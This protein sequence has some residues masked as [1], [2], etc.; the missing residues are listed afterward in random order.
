MLQKH[1]TRTLLAPLLSLLVIAAC[2]P[3]G[4]TVKVIENSAELNDVVVRLVGAS[5]TK[6]KEPS[7]FIEL[8]TKVEIENASKEPVTQVSY[9]IKLIG[10]D[11]EELRSY[12]ERYTAIDGAIAPGE[13]RIDDQTGC[14]WRDD[15]TLAGISI[16][17]VNVKTEAQMPLVHLPQTGEYLY[18]ALGN[19]RIANIKNEAPSKMTVGI[20]QGGFLREAR[21]E[22]PGDVARAVELFCDIRVGAQ[23]NEWVT[24][25]YNYIHFEWPDGSTS[26]I[27]LNLRN[28]EFPAYG[29]SYM[30]ELENL[31]GLWSYAESAVQEV[32]NNGADS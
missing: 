29:T 30:Y 17:N 24:D 6:V 32:R 4:S 18:Q 2:A 1:I 9:S 23:T 21:F 5:T 31:S 16:G 13:K 20:D 8:S 26:G 12:G 14:R 28:L 15:G 7:G 10:K 3:S 22:T 11:G 25:N 19:E 27:S